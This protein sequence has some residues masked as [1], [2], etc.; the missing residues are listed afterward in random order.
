[1]SELQIQPKLVTVDGNN[2]FQAYLRTEICQC[3][4]C[5]QCNIVSLSLS[6]YF[7]Y[8]GSNRLDFLRQ[9]EASGL[10]FQGGYFNAKPVCQECLST[11][12]VLFQC[13]QCKEMRLSVDMKETF[14]IH[15]SDFLCVYCYNSMTAAEWDKVYDFLEESHQY[16]DH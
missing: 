7:P 15:P 4:Q 3:C 2:Y 5:C 16:D 12:R 8:S 14:G 13:F 11:G 1:M 6:G 10:K 9:I